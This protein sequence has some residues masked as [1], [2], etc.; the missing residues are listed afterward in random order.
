MLKTAG[1][2]VVLGRGPEAQ[3]V[4]AAQAAFGVAAG[5]IQHEPLPVAGGCAQMAVPCGVQGL[6]RGG[7]LEER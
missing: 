1:Q 3:D 5:G 6:C 7:T 2:W 4:R